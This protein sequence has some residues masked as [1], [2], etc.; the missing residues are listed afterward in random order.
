MA[1]ILSS[2]QSSTK[3]R[4]LETITLPP[5]NKAPEARN[6]VPFI[7]FRSVNAMVGRALNGALSPFSLVRCCGRQKPLLYWGGD[8]EHFRQKP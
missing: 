6:L 8:E 3:V 1:G 4:K 7:D 2:S 5:L